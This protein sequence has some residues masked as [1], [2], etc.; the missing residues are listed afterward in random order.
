MKKGFKRIL[1]Q[2]LAVMLVFSAFSQIVPEASAASYSSL[3]GLYELRPSNATSTRLDVSG[4]STKNK[5]NIQIYTSNHTLAQQFYLVEAAEA[6]KYYYIVSKVSG[7][8]LDVSGGKGKSNDNVIQYTNKRGKNQQ[9]KFIST[10]GGYYIVP[11]VNESLALTAT[12]QGSGS[13]VCVQTR[14]N[15][16]KSQ[17]WQI[18]KSKVVSGLSGCTMSNPKALSATFSINTTGKNAEFTVDP[19]AQDVLSGVYKTTSKC[20]LKI[21]ISSGGKIIKTQNITKSRTIDIPKG[22]SNIVVKISEN[23]GIIAQGDNFAGGVVACQL[24]ELKN[25]VMAQ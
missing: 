11:R 16:K 25:C 8:V 10:S 19:L 12:G 21:T 17:I 18:A 4:G 2:I 20:N 7:K 14:V 5:A 1:C 13:N 24:T 15:N 6:G 22:Y 23:S 9:W 3:S